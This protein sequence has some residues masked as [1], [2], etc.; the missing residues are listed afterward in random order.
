MKHRRKEQ[1]ESQAKGMRHLLCQGHCLAAPCQ[2]LIRIPQ[3]P[4]RPGVMT[5]AYHASIR[6]IEK[7]VGAVLLAI[8]EGYAL[9]QVRVRSGKRSQVV[10]GRSQGTMC[11]DKH[12][13][14]LHLPG[15][16]EEALAKFVCRLQ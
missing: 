6:P 2:P 3:M 14:V 16:S 15:E 4:Q 7:R 8:V 5:P 13:S 12:G 11:R 9:G 1:S 10:Q